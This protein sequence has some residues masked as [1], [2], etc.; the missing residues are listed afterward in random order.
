MFI[1][2]QLLKLAYLVCHHSYFIPFAFVCNDVFCNETFVESKSPR[3]NDTS[4]K[5]DSN[6]S[7]C[8]AP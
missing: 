5:I 8:I 3:F 7:T 6:D 2:G 4:N 1:N